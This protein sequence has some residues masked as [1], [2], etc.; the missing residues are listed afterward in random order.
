[1]SSVPF[2]PGLVETLLSP[3]P[4]CLGFSQE[5]TEEGLARSL[6]PSLLSH[7]TNSRDYSGRIFAAPTTGLKKDNAI[8]YI[9]DQRVCFDV[10]GIYLLSFVFQVRQM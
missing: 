3:P 7:F 4:L 8:A 5:A 9:V 1:M 6:A 10:G 2:F